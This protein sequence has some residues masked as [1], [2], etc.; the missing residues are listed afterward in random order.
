MSADERTRAHRRRGQVLLDRGALPG[1]G[2]DASDAHGIPAGDRFVVA[3]LRGAAASVARSGRAG[4]GGRLSPPGARGA[5]TRRGGS[6]AVLGEL[7]LRGA[8]R[9]QRRGRHEHLAQALDALDDPTRATPCSRCVLE[10]LWIAA[11]PAEVGRC[12]CEQLDR[13]SRA[14]SDLP[15]AGARWPDHRTAH[16]DQSSIR[17]PSSAAGR[18]RRRQRSAAGSAAERRCW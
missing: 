5:A 12:S 17:S 18:R 2:G 16:C 10:S 1:A 9:R 8:S 15:G 4:R 7:G 14:S 11:S 13:R 6:R 3:T